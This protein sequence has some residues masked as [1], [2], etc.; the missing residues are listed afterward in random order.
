MSVSLPDQIV[1]IATLASLA[2]FAIG[3]L[4]MVGRRRRAESEQLPPILH[5]GRVHA[6]FYHP[7]DFIWVGVIFLF[8]GLNAFIDK[9]ADP[10][11]T[12]GALVATVLLQGTVAAMTAAAVLLRGVSLDVWVGWRWKPWPWMM[13]VAPLSVV[14]MWGLM[15]SL[16]AAGYQKWLE[17]LGAKS[18]QATVE[19]LRESQDPWLLGLMAIVAVFVAPLC[20]ELVFRGFLYPVAKRFAGRVTAA[21]FTALF[22]AACHGE[23]VGL[24]PLFILGLL[25]SELYERT[26][27]LWA[28]IAVH[29][30]FN[31]STV[32]LQ[33]IG[34]IFHI[35]L[36]P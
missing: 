2:V 17:G 16:H 28:P 25:L 5:S 13:L 26:G 34:R 4:I 18:S 24:L 8:F 19:L 27:S 23:L 22:F 20:E 14:S 35:P 15:L 32:L 36:E 12:I 10:T 6:Y 7:L 29:F 11:P 9:G 30:C 33:A 31:G 3:A 21:L 1:Q